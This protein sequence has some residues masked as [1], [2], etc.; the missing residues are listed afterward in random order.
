MFTCG[1]ENYSLSQGWFS[2]KNYKSIYKLNLSGCLFAC[3]DPINVKR[4]ETIGSKC[5][6][7]PHV[8]P[9]KVFE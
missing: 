7:G 9:G 6:V 1:K 4:T 5:Y 2:V 8:T 3:L